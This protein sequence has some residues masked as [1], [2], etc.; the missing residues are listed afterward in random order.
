MTSSKVVVLRHFYFIQ[1][2]K[3]SRSWLND[4]DVTLS[5]VIHNLEFFGLP[6]VLNIIK[7]GFVCNHFH[8]TESNLQYSQSFQCK[9]P[10]EILP[11]V[12]RTLPGSQ[13]RRQNCVFN[14]FAF[15]QASTYYPD[16]SSEPFTWSH[17]TVNFCGM[18]WSTTCVSHHVVS[19]TKCHGCFP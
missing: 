16:L 11:A 7:S 15:I 12:T 5:W 19:L 17:E 9:L 3:I 2:T 13:F 6:D 10:W 1:P 8:S 14:K 4:L 18:K